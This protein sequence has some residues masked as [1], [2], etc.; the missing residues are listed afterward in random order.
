MANSQAWSDGGVPMPWAT[1]AGSGGWFYDT[2]ARM[3][4]FVQKNRALFARRENC[5]N[6]GLVYSLPTYAWREFSAFG[7]SSEKYRKWYVALARILEEMHIPY[8]VNCWWHPLLGDEKASMVRLSKYK[9]LILPGVDCFSDDQ[10]EAVRTFQ[11]GGGRVVHL[12]CP[13]LYNEDAVP[14]GPDQT[15]A[16]PGKNLFEI[17][18]ELLE[19][20]ISENSSQSSENEEKRKKATGKLLSV[21]SAALA[22]DGMLKT[23][24]HADIWSNVWL[25][26]T[27]KVLALH[28]VN[29]DMDEGNDT[30][31][32]VE[33][34]RWSVR[35]PEGLSV[36][37]ALVISPDGSTAS[38]TLP[39]ETG[40]GWAT[41][42]VPRVESY[43][44]VALYAGDALSKAERAAKARRAEWMA[45]VAYQNAAN[46]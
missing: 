13:K 10:R 32:I 21:I 26:N 38:E 31:R 1:A 14:R 24:A 34:S 40:K 41:V 9:V 45:F 30:F 36:S 23:D 15:L 43:S 12:S 6:V 5:A 3:C 18:P 33:R 29:G 2:E 25:D 4:R 20:Y 28:L 44:V 46:F 42:V 8:E 7:L 16:V 27:G 35:L 22:G 19:N 37:E 11:A 17:K 39:V